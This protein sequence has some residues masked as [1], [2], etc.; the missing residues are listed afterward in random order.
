MAREKE[1]ARAM[2]REVAQAIPDAVRR[3]PNLRLTKAQVAALQ[4][5]FQNRLIQ[6]MGKK[7]GTAGRAKA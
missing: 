4:R 6:T 2:A 3:V 1:W 5:A 7:S